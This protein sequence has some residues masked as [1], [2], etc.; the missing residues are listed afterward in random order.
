MSS[1]HFFCLWGVVFA[2]SLLQ[3]SKR[4]R[5][6]H[7]MLLFYLKRS[8]Q[9]AQVHLR[10][11]YS[12]RVCTLDGRM[13]VMCFPCVWNKHGPI[14]APFYILLP[15]VMRA[16]VM[17]MSLP[18]LIQ[19]KKRVM[20]VLRTATDLFQNTPQMPQVWSINWVSGMTN[21]TIIRRKMFSQIF[22]CFEH[23]VEASHTI[24]KIGN[25]KMIALFNEPL[26]G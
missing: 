18:C 7:K 2:M 1:C 17:R 25:S 14:R 20:T 12:M 13:H 22:S 24:K 15:Q 26:R 8:W 6:A 3:C 23:V 4:T 11:F 5:P 21:K 10:R 16:R 19:V 9:A